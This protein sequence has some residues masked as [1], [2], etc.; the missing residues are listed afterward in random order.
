MFAAVD[1][2]TL[3]AASTALLG[4]LIARRSARVDKPTL[5]YCHARIAESLLSRMPTLKAGYVPPLLH[6]TGILQS[7]LADLHDVPDAA[8]AYD[9]EELEL[10][11]LVLDEKRS[12]CCPDLVPDG[13]VSVD[14]LPQPDRAAPIVILVSGLTGSSSSVFIRRAAVTLHEAG[15]RVCAFNPRGRGGNALKTPFMYSAGFTEDLRRVVLH[16]REAYPRAR[17]TAAGYSL[18]ASYLGKYV[19]EEGADCPLDGAALLA[20]PTDLNAAIGNFGASTISRCVDRFVL[21]RS[22]QRVMAEYLPKL[23][24]NPYGL[25]LEGAAQATSMKSF[26][27][28]VIAPMMGCSSAEQYYTEASCERVLAD[29]R[30]PLLL[31]SARNDFI[32]PA[33]LIKTHPFE[34]LAGGGAVEAPLLLAVTSEGGHSMSWPEGW[35]GSGRAWSAQV[36]LEWVQACVE[37][38]GESAPPPARPR[39]RARSPAAR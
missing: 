22:V 39:R 10:P 12:A 2:P 25:D 18:G 19:G 17:L 30:I 5:T 37:K 24:D 8:V 9:R 13:L 3:A 34:A 23:V 35:D 27:G 20:C 29:C 38:A 14:W 32:A 7:R 16:V 31:L 28:C 33:D 6:P 36:L 21:T 11:K 15:F 4:A 1:A 26:D